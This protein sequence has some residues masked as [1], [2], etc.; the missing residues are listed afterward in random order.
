MNKCLAYLCVRTF[1]R[2]ATR[3]AKILLK[4][5]PP[6]LYHYRF[7]VV[8][9]QFQERPPF[10]PTQV[11][12]YTLDHQGRGDFYANVAC[13]SRWIRCQHQCAETTE[14]HGLH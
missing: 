13:N 14:G 11:H 1:F 6:A 12:F 7:S 10:K 4:T 2:C 3:R 5:H 8:Q 9:V